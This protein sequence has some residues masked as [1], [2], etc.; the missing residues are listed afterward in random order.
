MYILWITK[1]CGNNGYNK[2][3]RINTINMWSDINI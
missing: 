2:V 1:G 3:F